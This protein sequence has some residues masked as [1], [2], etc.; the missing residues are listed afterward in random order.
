MERVNGRLVKKRVQEAIDTCRKEGAFDEIH[1]DGG[2]GGDT[3]ID[4]DIDNSREEKDDNGHGMPSTEELMERLTKEITQSR[5]PKEVTV[6]EVG[7]LEKGTGSSNI[8]GKRS[9]GEVSENV[10]NHNDDA[11]GEQ[12]TADNSN[13]RQRPCCPLCFRTNPSQHSPPIC[14]ICEESSLCSQCYSRCMNCYRLTCADCLMGC[15]SCGSRQYCSDC[16]MGCGGQCTLCRPLKKGSNAKKKPKKGTP[17]SHLIRMTG[18]PFPKGGYPAGATAINGPPVAHLERMTGVPFPKGG[19]S[20]G[21]TT[22]NGPPVAHLERTT[23]PF[24]K[25]GYSA[26]TTKTNGPTNNSVNRS[27]APLQQ[28][29]NGP[30]NGSQYQPLQPPQQQPKEL[31][32]QLYSTHRFIITE[33]G[34]LGLTIGHD[35]ETQH[36]SVRL[37]QPKSITDHHGVQ[38]NDVI[39][40]PFGGSAVN[41]YYSFVEACKQRP[42]IF[43]VKRPSH[44][45]AAAG[46]SSQS[47]HRFIITET[48]KLGITIGEGKNCMTS[49]THVVPNS[50]ADIHGV[51]ANDVICKP[52]LE[53][54]AN[55]TTYHWFMDLVASGKR[56]LVFEVWR[57]EPA[58]PANDRDNLAI[59]TASSENP[60]TYRPAMPAAACVTNEISMS[61]ESTD[62]KT[63]VA[64]NASTGGNYA[65]ANI[66]SDSGAVNETTMTDR[67]VAHSTSSAVVA[68]A[69]S[70]GG[71]ST[72]QEKAHGSADEDVIS[73]NDDSTVGSGCAGS[74]E[75]QNNRKKSNFLPNDYDEKEKDAD[76]NDMLSVNSKLVSD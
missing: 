47:L 31:P 48:G 18:A 6:N 53:G 52:F 58:T 16:M 2:D 40:R 14:N 20:A 44:P 7:Q 8:N 3:L 28:H 24:L 22:M 61:A 39:I 72:A 54:R 27:V 41:C 37:I 57:K 63:T 46:Q 74:E 64:V 25:G 33:T 1:D 26:G 66:Q 32:S 11:E 76:E 9:Q 5:D 21:A 29:T 15:D 38:T 12:H 56:P 51:R 49:I 73:I 10:G 70:N 65:R 50:T 62:K 60:F 71:A 36:A 19:Y 30:L 45:P 17:I 43:E 59:H 75:S 4:I 69:P 68:K 55:I 13:K 67:G 34:T 35:P 42:L 23:V